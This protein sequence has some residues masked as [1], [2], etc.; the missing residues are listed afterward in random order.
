[1]KNI[2]LKVEK[3][4]EKEIKNNTARKL[5]RADYL[6]AVMY[7][8][9]K[10]PA[11]I[12]IKRKELTTLLKGH[13]ILSVIFDIQIDEKSK[14]SE[15][16][17]IKEYQRDPISRK[18]MHL[19][20]LRIEMKKEIET[21]VPIRILNEDIAIGIKDDG[22]VLQHGLREFRILCL[23]ANIPEQ[24]DYDIKELGMNEIIRV[25]N[26]E[27]DEK[28]KILNDPAEV[29]VSIIPPTELKEE[30]LVTE[31]EGEEGAEE[32]EVVGEKK[33]EE[34]GGDVAEGKAEDKQKESRKE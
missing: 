29:I 2:A 6:P 17:I 30:D 25:E 31:E 27:V 34:E 9:K 1:M 13:S 10:E 14:D 20:F 4:N 5:D 24:I 33:P 11:I 7:G 22:G 28:I 16:V 19:D 3:R 12:K 18:L 23:P 32:P 26:I 8:L 15:A 21:V